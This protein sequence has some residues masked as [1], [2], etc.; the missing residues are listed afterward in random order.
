[1]AQTQQQG[2]QDANAGEREE[3]GNNVASAL[4]Q[5]NLM[6]QQFAS[7]AATVLQQIQSQAVPSKPRLKALKARRVNGELI[8]EPIYDDAPVV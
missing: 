7:S 8:A 1:V 5:I 6:A 4:A 3:L 2:Q